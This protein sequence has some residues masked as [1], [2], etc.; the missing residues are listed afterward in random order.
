MTHHSNTGSMSQNPMPFSG[1]QTP[2]PTSIHFRGGGV[3]KKLYSTNT[4][5]RNIAHHNNYHNS[6]YHHQHQQQYFERQHNLIDDMGLE[7]GSYNKSMSRSF[8]NDPNPII[9]GRA[10]S[11]SQRIPTSQQFHSNSEQTSFNHAQ[12]TNSSINKLGVRLKIMFNNFI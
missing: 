4:Q 3:S 2:N 11:A 10:T 9:D 5:P 6:S 7:V 8:N 12:G 1:H